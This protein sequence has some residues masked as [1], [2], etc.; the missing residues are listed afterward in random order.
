MSNI[1]Y[2][3]PQNRWLHFHKF[4]L[5]GGR[6]GKGG[7][8]LRGWGDLR[9]RG[10]GRGEPG[11][12]FFWER[13]EVAAGWEWGRCSGNCTPRTCMSPPPIPPASLVSGWT[14]LFGPLER[15]CLP[16]SPPQTLPC[17]QR[18]LTTNDPKT[19]LK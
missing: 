10:Q 4:D 14:G 15:S 1:D 17:H 3:N 11:A 9:T 12:F 8:V 13:G 18:T 2:K 19:V 7:G 6:V 16:P 5:R